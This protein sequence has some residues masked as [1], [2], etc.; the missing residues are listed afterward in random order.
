MTL[1]LCWVFA[2]LAGWRGEG[3]QLQPS[4]RHL[5]REIDMRYMMLPIFTH[6]TTVAFKDYLCQ[7]LLLL[8]WADVNDEHRTAF[9]IIIWSDPPFETH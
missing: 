4:R 6:T 7:L 1:A 5:D 9:T 8:G 3:L 2:D